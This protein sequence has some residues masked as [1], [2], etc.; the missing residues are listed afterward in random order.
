[1]TREDCGLSNYTHMYQCIL[2]KFLATILTFVIGFGVVL[3][4]TPG[5]KDYKDGEMLRKQKKYAEALEAY[6]RAIDKE[7]NNY[8]YFYK[9]GVVLVKLNNN[10]DAIKAFQKAIELNS[11][12]SAGYVSI[13]QIYIRDRKF[14]DAIEY[15]NKAYDKETDVAKKIRYKTMVARLYLKDDKPDKALT[16]LNAAK[17]L[18]GG[19]VDL[20]VLYAEGEAY[21]RLEKWQQSLESY[22]KALDGAK[23]A[24]FSNKDLGQYKFGVGL[25]YAKLNNKAEYEKILA[26]LQST[27]PAW[28]QKL[29]RAAMGTE[30]GTYTRLATSYLKGGLYD[31]AAKNIATAIAN[32]ENLANSY[33][34]AAIINEKQG[35]TS[36]AIQ[37]YQKALNEEQNEQKKMTIYQRIIR[38]QLMNKAYDEAITVIDKVLAKKPDD[39]EL[40]FK[41]AQAQYAKGQYAAAL[42]TAES[43]AAKIP[44]SDPKQSI[45]QARYYL[46]AGMAAKNNKDAAKARDA[47]QKAAQGPYRFAAKEELKGVGG[48]APPPAEK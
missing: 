21:G 35:Q 37:N 22:A 36:Q 4:Q 43:A 47:L 16:E 25:A 14:A 19:N 31:E 39:L 5:A 12:F 33:F 18:P 20:G 6:N 30:S 41:K 9:K 45:K 26:D 42:A 1:M 23:R 10:N 27:N 24:Q 17:A 44:A 7:G 2:A 28:A 11:G 15:M 46:I 38:L 32:R 8:K 48:G 13:A 29:K 3:A 34:V 40:L